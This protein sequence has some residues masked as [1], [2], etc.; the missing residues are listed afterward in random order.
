MEL[1]HIFW[2]NEENWKRVYTTGVGGGR[3]RTVNT[4][5]LSLFTIFLLFKILLIA[6]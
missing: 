2:V 5:Y 6:V 3:G 4:L 1:T